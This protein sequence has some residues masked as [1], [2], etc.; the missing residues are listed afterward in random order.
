MFALIKFSNPVSL[1]KSLTVLVVNNAER[2]IEMHECETIIQKA[3]K[4]GQSSLLMDESQQICSYHHIPTPKSQVTTNEDE[5]VQKAKEIGFPV[6]MKIISPQI[7][8]KSDV[9]GVVLNISEEK[10]LRNEYEKLIDEVR[11]KEPSAYVAGVLVE[12]MMPASTEVIVGGIRDSQ[13]GASIMFGIGGIFA[14]VYDDVAFRVAPIDRIDAESLVHEL[15]GS[16]ILE[17]FRGKPVADLDSIIGVLTSVSDLMMMHNAINQLDLN[18]VIV[19][20][21]SVCAVDSRIII[22]KNEGA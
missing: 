8:H 11:R 5:A 18:P 16:K 10:Q 14:E 7:L 9:G 2:I 3:L 13:F 17:G 1:R 21:A 19:Y 6:V 22:G 15:K 20:P 4:E 12:K